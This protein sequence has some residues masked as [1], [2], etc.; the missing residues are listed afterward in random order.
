[1][2]ININANFS[3]IVLLRCLKPFTR[4]SFLQT[5]LT[6]LSVKKPHELV[7]DY[8]QTDC[9]YGVKLGHIKDICSMH[10]SKYLQAITYMCALYMHTCDIYNITTSLIGPGHWH[11]V[12]PD[13][14]APH[15]QLFVLKQRKEQD[16]ISQ[17]DFLPYFSVEESFCVSS[18]KEDKDKAFR[19]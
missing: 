1:M 12:I 2:H 11:K 6:N 10:T 16:I 19:I 3:L 15:L 5:F 9:E 7:N 14:P 8:E 18:R 17:K 13:I 4:L